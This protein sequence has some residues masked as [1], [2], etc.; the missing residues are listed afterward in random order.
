MEFL[1]YKL[2]CFYFHSINNLYVTSAHILTS[3][4]ITR[5]WYIVVSSIL[6]VIKMITV[7]IRSTLSLSE[8]FVLPVGSIEKSWHGC[9][10]NG[11]NW[12]SQVNWNG[13]KKLNYKWK[14]PLLHSRKIII[15]IYVYPSSLLLPPVTIP[16]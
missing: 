7:Y 4:S 2:I 10:F 16:C 12:T 15:S 3:L 1:V 13:E 5:K 11:I 14:R 6:T 8:V 9:W